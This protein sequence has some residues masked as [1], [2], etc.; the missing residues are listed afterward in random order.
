MNDIA[1]RVENLGKLYRMGQFVGYKTL[2]ESVVNVISAPF[3]RLRYPS[4]PLPDQDEYIWALKDVSFEVKPGEAVGIIGRNG[5]GKT[6]LLRILCRITTPTEGYAEVHGRVG[7]LLEVGTGFHPELTGRENIYLN[8]AVLG[9]KR[10]EID[11]KFDEIVDFSGVEK[12]IDTPLKRFSTGMQVRLAFSV[13]AHLEPE[14]LLVDEVLAVGDAAF[15]KRC[16]GKMGDIARGGRTV[17]FISHNMSAINQLCDYGVW[18]EEGRVRAILPAEQAVREYLASTAEAI[19]AER[20]PEDLSK[21]AQFLQVQTVDTKGE[22]AK[23]LDRHKPIRLD[24]KFILRQNIPGLYITFSL[25][26]IDGLRVLFSDCA[27]EMLAS[28]IPTEPGQY[29]AHATIPPSLLA[30]GRYIV[31]AGLASQYLGPIDRQDMV[32][33]FDLFDV[34]SPRG[35]GRRPVLAVPINWEIGSSERT[36]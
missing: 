24:F 10:K 11:R 32:H 36:H 8:G 22:A 30:Q 19:S 21:S 9:M 35:S 12:F 23:E 13:A 4:S 18:L 28:S 16:L 27:E 14:I 25:Q 31:T 26:T 3:R 33:A 1:I 34:K 2:R 20:L 5:A 29:I 17:L 15:Q 6:T 7:S